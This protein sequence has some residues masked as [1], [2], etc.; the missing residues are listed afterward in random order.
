[1]DITNVW[2]TE[3]SY[4]CTITVDCAVFGFQEGVLKVLLVKKLHNPFK[5][6]WLLPGGIMSEDKTAEQAVNEVLFRLTGIQD[7]HQ[8]Q[9]HSYT[10]LFRHPLKRVITIC[11][12][13]LIKPENH[14]IINQKQVDGVQ[15]FHLDELPTLGFDHVNLVR[16]SLNKLRSNVEERLILGE[17]LPRKFTLMELQQLYESLL[18]KKLDRRNFRKKIMQKGLLKKSGEKKPGVKGG[19]DLFELIEK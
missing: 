13:A 17:L 12:Y 4:E 19:P 16:D 11:F 18:D 1:M 3:K 10:E 7:V 2:V 5:G 9:V 14:P 15:W 8:T 6:Y